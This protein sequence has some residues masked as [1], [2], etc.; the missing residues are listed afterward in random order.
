[1]CEGGWA[2]RV[3]PAVGG[4]GAGTR[5]SPAQLE[6]RLRVRASAWQGLKVRRW[7]SVAGV[8]RTAMKERGQEARRR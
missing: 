3:L 6:A 5:Y 1:M 8:W 2:V 7:I 4:P